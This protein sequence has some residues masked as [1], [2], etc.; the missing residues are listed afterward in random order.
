MSNIIGI[1]IGAKGALA[2]LSPTAN[3][4]RWRICRSCATARLVGPM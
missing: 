1:D 3:C 4:S 2:L